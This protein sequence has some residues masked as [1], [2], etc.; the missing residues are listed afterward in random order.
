MSET[1]FMLPPVPHMTAEKARNTACAWKAMSDHL[2]EL[3]DA[4]GARLALTQ[5][6]W[7]LAYSIALAQTGKPEGGQ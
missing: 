2:A 3:P 6:Q 4:A 7:W 5:S 1:P